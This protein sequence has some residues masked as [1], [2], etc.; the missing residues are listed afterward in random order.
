MEKIIR[1][2]FVLGILFI[3]DSGLF[4]FTERRCCKKVK[5][6]CEECKAWSCKRKEIL[7]EEN[8]KKEV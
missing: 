2:L 8:K 5:G 4:R 3:Y 1:V 7:Y 6:N